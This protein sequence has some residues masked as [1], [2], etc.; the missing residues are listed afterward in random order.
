MLETELE[1]IEALDWGE[2][3]EAWGDAERWES[4]DKHIWEDHLI[5]RGKS[6]SFFS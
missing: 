3:V 2:E 4:E 5:P 6:A 1:G